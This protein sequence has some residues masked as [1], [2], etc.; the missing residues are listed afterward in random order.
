MANAHADDLKYISKSLP[1]NESLSTN[2]RD[3]ALADGPVVVHILRFLWMY[4]EQAVLHPRIRV[5]LAFSILIMHC[6]GLRPGE[7]GKSKAHH[8]S[9]E[10]LLWKDID[11]EIIPGNKGAP[12]FAA[13]LRIRN[14]K[15]RR[16]RDGEA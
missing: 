16:Y 1:E 10:G 4:D 14:R 15:G 11:I 2:A 9:R 5:Q 7:R 6:L 12:L 3:E 8:G 13:Q